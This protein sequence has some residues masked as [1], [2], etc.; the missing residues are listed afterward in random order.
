[1]GEKAMTWIGHRPLNVLWG[2][3]LFQVPAKSTKNP[4]TWTGEKE[5][6]SKHLSIYAE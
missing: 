3:L 4:L 2:T 1:M 6:E 5:A